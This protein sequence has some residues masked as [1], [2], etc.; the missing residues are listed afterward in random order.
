MVE[1]D[2]VVL[3]Q[4]LAGVPLEILLGRGEEGADGVRHEVQHQPVS[5]SVAHG[6]QGLEALEARVVDAAA[7]LAV[8]RLRRVVGE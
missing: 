2:L 6:I 4:I 1:D 7:T 8:R 3:G 5:A